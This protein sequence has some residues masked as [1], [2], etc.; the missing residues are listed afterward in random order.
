MVLPP[1]SDSALLPLRLSG[2]DGSDTR[3]FWHVH[4]DDGNED[5]VGSGTTPRSQ[6]R[7]RKMGMSEKAQKRCVLI[8]ALE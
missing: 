8:L 4:E 2:G 1:G 5:D 6:C 3:R 7:F